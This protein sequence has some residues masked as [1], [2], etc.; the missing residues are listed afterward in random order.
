M[1]GR[2]TV[3]KIADNFS[4]HNAKNFA[5][6]FLNVAFYSVMTPMTMLTQSQNSN[7]VRI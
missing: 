1:I 5:L 4:K 3:V 6:K 2:D 7:F